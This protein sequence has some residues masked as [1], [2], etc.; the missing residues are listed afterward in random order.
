VSWYIQCGD[1]VGIAVLDFDPVEKSV[2]FLV[3]LLR[4]YYILPVEFELK[5]IVFVGHW[6][7]IDLL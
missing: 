5:L 3:V 4:V 6:L 2:E 1:A 7:L